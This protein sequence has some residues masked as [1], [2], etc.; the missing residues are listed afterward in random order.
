MKIKQSKMETPSTAT[1]LAS[2]MQALGMYVGANSEAEHASEANRVGSAIYYH[3]LLANALLG[4]VETEAILAESLGVTPAQ[5]RAAH[6]QA[7]SSAGAESH[8]V[9][10]FGVLRW[11]TLRVAGP[12]AEMAYNREVGRMPLA[13]SHAAEG[14][15]RLL[16]VCMEE[17]QPATASPTQM[18]TELLLAQE[19]LSAASATIDSMLQLI[20]EVEKLS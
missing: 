20:A 3:M 4:M 18:K 5:M 16:G 7:L 9:K 8:P 17:Q 12:L 14:L 1:Q 19:A 11:R 15:Q 6:Q 10:L 13:A 2:A